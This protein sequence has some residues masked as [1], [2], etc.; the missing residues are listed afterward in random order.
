MFDE[1]F[2]KRTGQLWK[3]YLFMV[4]LGV[5]FAAVLFALTNRSGKSPEFLVINM[6][7]GCG[8]CIATTV[9]VCLSVT[10][11]GCKVRLVWLYMTKKSAANWFAALVYLT[12]CPAC[13]HAVPERE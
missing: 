11:P 4:L 7:A 13:G 9:W 12:Q 2:L 8:L 6:L 5:G 10:C 1:S 3:L